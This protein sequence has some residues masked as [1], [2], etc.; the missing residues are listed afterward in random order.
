MKTTKMKTQP[1]MK[2]TQATATQADEARLRRQQ[3]E[4]L[5]EITERILAKFHPLTT[6]E[7]RSNKRKPNCTKSTKDKTFVISNATMSH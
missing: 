2:T 5:R 6:D 4:K 7:R 1:K 3:I